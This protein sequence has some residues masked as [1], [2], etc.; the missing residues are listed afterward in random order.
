MDATLDDDLRGFK[1]ILSLLPPTDPLDSQISALTQQPTVSTTTTPTATPA[2]TRSFVVPLP[3]T[4]SAVPIATA[5]KPPPLKVL[6]PNFKLPLVTSNFRIKKR[7]QIVRPYKILT[8]NTPVST[9]QY[10]MTIRRQPLHP[11]E[12]NT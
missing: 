12:L 9:S 10:L 2:S 6:P 5:S 4:T 3:H 8:A 7:T 11:N 1:D